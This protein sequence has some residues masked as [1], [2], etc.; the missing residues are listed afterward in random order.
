MMMD[1]PIDLVLI[2]F[3]LGWWGVF[4]TYAND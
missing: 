1:E 4:S 2:D 3:I